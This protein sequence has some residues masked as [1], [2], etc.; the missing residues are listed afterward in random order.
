MNE[1][2]DGRI[3]E[4]IKKYAQ[5]ET[6]AIVELASEL[7][8]VTQPDIRQRHEARDRILK[9]VELHAQAELLIEDAV[10]TYREDLYFVARRLADDELDSGV[11]TRAHVRHAQAMLARGRKK[12]GWGDALLAV[13]GLML[14]AAIPHIIYLNQSGHAANVLLI[15]SGVIGGM[16]FGMGALAKAKG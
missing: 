15:V 7:R 2:D 6:R 14:G 10:A 5:L 4:I 3:E 13:G 16:M 11:V 9:E 8:S 12:Y 1:P